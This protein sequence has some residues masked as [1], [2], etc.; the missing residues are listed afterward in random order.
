MT[1]VTLECL[2]KAYDGNTHV[3][4]EMTLRIEAGEFLVVVGP[5]GCGKSTLLR[6]IAGLELPSKGQIYF[7]ETLVTHLPPQ[8]RDVGMVFQN[9]ALYPHMTV[10]ENLAFPLR[11]RKVSKA[12]QQQRVREVASLLGLEHMLDRYPRQLSGGQQQRVAVGRALVRSPRV[13][14]F[15][16]PLSNL[17]AQL[18]V[19]MR[20]ELTALQH[21]LGITTI[22]VTH[23]HTEAMTMGDRIAVL[24][25]GRI[26]QHGTPQ[27]LYCD[28]EDVFVATFLGT[29]S[30]NL[31]RGSLE[32]M[33]EGIVFRT[34]Q[35]ELHLQLDATVFRHRLP[36]QGSA[37]AGIRAEHVVIA[38]EGSADAVATIER[39]EFV[40]HERIAYVRIGSVQL[41]MRLPATGHL[42]SGTYVPV[43][44]ERSALLFF[45]EDGNRL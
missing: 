20:G 31:L 41:C 5:S 34:E 12:E 2:S 23:D 29:P 26:V 33:A 37:V 16:E 27:Q 17:D 30:I 14:L 18:R 13:F 45:G 32:Q 39:V 44:F 9:Y 19:Q 4:D 35:G 25:R 42:S 24:H 43:H 7:N 10:A 1:T 28:P 15:D 36:A 40:G 6:L 38:S 3:L 21:R 11:V 8:H 22:Y